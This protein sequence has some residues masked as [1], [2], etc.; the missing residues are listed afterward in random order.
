MKI[1]HLAAIAIASLSISA[2]FAQAKP[3]DQI[4]YRQSAMT[5]TARSVGVLS[6]M[7]KGDLPFNKELAQRHA[8]TIADL[9]DLP[10][11]AGAYGPGTDKGAPTK[12]DPKIWSEADKFKAAFDKF[13]T[14]ARSLPA[15]AGDLNSL[16]TA[17]ADLGK[18]CKGCHDDYRMK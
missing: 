7:A 9:S 17:L 4:K 3:E 1:Q 16:K 11:T 13:S 10:L 2:A 6:A 18:T 15:A 14:S 5:V 8:S 12:A